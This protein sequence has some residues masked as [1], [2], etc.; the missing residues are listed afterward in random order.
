M[1]R[2][3]LR[4]I[5]DKRIPQAVRHRLGFLGIITLKQGLTLEIYIS[6]LT[7]ILTQTPYEYN[8]VAKAI[9]W[10][11]FREKE[12]ETAQI[13]AKDFRGGIMD[14]SLGDDA[15]KI[16]RKFLRENWTY[17]DRVPGSDR[18]SQGRGNR[19][20]EQIFRR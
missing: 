3:D 12:G 18:E 20:I 16:A 4:N 15:L 11:S 9:N 1:A 13:S 10:A 17:G 6:R 2:G 5:T 7:A 14:E 8:A 19:T